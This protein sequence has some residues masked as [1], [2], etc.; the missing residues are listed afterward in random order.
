MYIFRS[1]LGVLAILVLIGGLATS[2]AAIFSKSAKTVKHGL[3]V[4]AAALVALFIVV[5][6][7]RPPVRSPTSGSAEAP[8]GRTSYF[9]VPK[10]SAFPRCRELAW[11]FDANRTAAFAKTVEAGCQ[12]E[13]TAGWNKPG[14]KVSED[15]CERWAGDI[16]VA[17]YK[18]WRVQEDPGNMSAVDGLP[19]A[20]DRARTDAAACTA[21]GRQG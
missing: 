11:A 12:A 10:T 5:P 3:L 20:L 9:P 14:S 17:A 2:V 18:F 7:E 13:V 21:A 16:Q 15:P 8:V 6:T 4:A 1:I 19:M